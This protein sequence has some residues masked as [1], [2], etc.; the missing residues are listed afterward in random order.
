MKKVV[1]LSESELTRLVKRIISEQDIE[2]D[3]DEFFASA[4]HTKQGYYDTSDRPVKYV[5]G[6]HESKTFGPD[7]YDDF[8]EYINNCN[9]KWCL[10]TK[11]FYDMYTKG[12]PLTVAKRKKR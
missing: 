3:E 5:E 10:T 2:S 8:M 6:Y 1:R 12:G 11:K 9:T 7:E 4:P